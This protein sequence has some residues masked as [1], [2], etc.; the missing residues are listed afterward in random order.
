METNISVTSVEAT[1]F[2]RK[3]WLRRHISQIALHFVILLLMFFTL[4]PLVLLVMDSF[5]SYN[6]FQLEP[7]AFPNPVILDNYQ[8][9]WLYV[10]DF[11]INSIVITVA[12]TVIL[13]AIA[14]I[15]AYAFSRMEFRFKETLFMAMLALMMVPGM[16]NVISQYAMINKFNLL[17][18]Y[19]GVIL[20]SVTG[21]IPY[22]VFLFRTFFSGIP[23]ELFEAAE[24]DGASHGRM[25][26]SIMIPL[27]KPIVA[28]LTISTVLS[29]WNDYLWPLLVLTRDIMKTISVGLVSWTDT[30]YQMTSSYGA[31]FAGYVLSSLPLVIVFSFCSKQFIAGLT[32]GAL[33]M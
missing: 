1:D 7:F 2:K 17:N 29:Q 21:S 25:L 26:V 18:D 5:K 28:T 12:V 3:N 6:Q 20:P 14:T 9:A 27:A 22:S 19:W 23:D 30:Y 13:V 24:L 16:L 10:K 15:T 11:M 4:L 8:F 33:K 31:P 32:S